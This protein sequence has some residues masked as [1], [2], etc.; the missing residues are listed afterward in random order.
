MIARDH[1]RIEELIAARALDALDETGIAELEREQATHGPDCPVCRELETA[2]REVGGRLAFALDPEPVPVGMVDR[3]V[4]TPAARLRSSRALR[5][6]RVAAI[7][8][9]AALVLAGGIGGFLVRGGPG[10]PR[11]VPLASTGRAGALALVYEPGARSSYLVGSGLAGVP[12][13][14]VYELWVIRGRSPVPAG[15]FGARAPQVVLQVGVPVSGATEVA[16]TVEPKP[17]SR[18][19]TTRP[20]FSAP[21]ES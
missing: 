20:V 21:I 10:A 17:G 11:V 2:Y 15:T 6:R 5:W 19:P 12:R 8:A 1:S 7:G 16:V 4:A 9:A 13:N 18:Q 3:I 14:R